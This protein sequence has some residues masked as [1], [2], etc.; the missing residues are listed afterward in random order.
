M[1]ADRQDVPGLP[2]VWL[3]KFSNLTEIIVTDVMVNTSGLNVIL[4]AIKHVKQ[5]KFSN[6]NITG[7]LPVNT[8][9]PNLTS[10]DLSGN[11]FHGGIPK[12]I[13]KL[14][15]LQ[16]IDLSD[17]QLTGRVPDAFS[18]MKRLQKVVL[19]SNELSGSIPPTVTGLSSLMYLDLSKNKFNGSVP[20][21][22]NS[23][24]ALRYLD[25][26]YND[27]SGPLPFNKTF[28]SKLNTLK[29]KGNSGI[30]YNKTSL[31]ISFLVGIPN[32]DSSGLPILPSSASPAL[33]PGGAV[34]PAGQFAA[35]SPKHSHGGPKTIV[36][37]V[38]ITLV[39]IVVFIVVVVLISKCRGRKY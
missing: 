25:L 29:V 26:S 38:A 15:L 22:I 13:G 35:G 12:T 9:P 8:W 11:A 20:E 37:A 31:K 32:C 10:I 14:N 24:K 21:A 4:S 23:M 3:S 1:T 28:L 18:K 36:A 17:N 5:I 7:L 6:T 39:V 16:E 19:Q 27:F 33:S 30:C 2:G 34:A